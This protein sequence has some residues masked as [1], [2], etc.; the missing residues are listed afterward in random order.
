MRPPQRRLAEPPP[1]RVLVQAEQLGERHGVHRIKR[2]EILKL[3]LRRESVP[4]ADFLA[5]VAPKQPIA[6]ASAQ[7]P[8]HLTFKLNREI[9]DAS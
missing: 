6:H 3:R 4:R 2:R 1:K 7:L 9:T 5:N 8:R